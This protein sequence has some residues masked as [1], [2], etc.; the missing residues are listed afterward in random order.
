MC[1]LGAYTFCMYRGHHDSVA[2]CFRDGVLKLNEKSLRA[3]GC[4]LPACPSLHSCRRGAVFV[5]FIS[6]PVP[7]FL[8]ALSLFGKLTLVLCL[9]LFPSSL[10][11]FLRFHS[12][13][14]FYFCFHLYL[15]SFSYFLF[16]LFKSLSSFLPSSSL[17]SF[18][19]LLCRSFWVIMVIYPALL[20]FTH[21]ISYLSPFP[22]PLYI[23]SCPSRFIS[24]FPTA[25][26]S[27]VLF[28]TNSELHI[29]QWNCT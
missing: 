8:R 27:H 5:A 10:S 15:C 23:S 26:F 11:S 7:S 9:S 21:F 12:I 25:Q 24:F 22:F 28:I 29:V 19:I 4:C 2:S 17:L 6:S 3:N 16:V 14:F 13:Y 18:L 20:S 1:K